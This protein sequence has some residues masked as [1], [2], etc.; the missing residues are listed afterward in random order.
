MRSTRRVAATQGDGPRDGR[1]RHRQG[2]DRSGGSSTQPAADGPLCPRQLRPAHE[3][4]LESEL[5]GHIKGAF[6]GAIDNKTG[7]FEAAHGGTIS[8]MKSPA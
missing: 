5:F 2:T 1:N 4:L 8:S 3:S 6:T 7:R